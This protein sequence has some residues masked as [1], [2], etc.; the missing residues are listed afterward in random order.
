MT[1]RQLSL[2]ALTVM[3]L[4]PDRM[5]TCAAEAGYDC[6]GL[7]LLPAT[8]TEPTWPCIGDTSLVREIERR[9]ADTG[10]RMLDIEIFRLLP[11]TD[12]HTFRPAL[13]T[14]ARLGATQVLVGAYDR[15]PQRLSDRFGALCDLGAPLGLSM[16]IEPMP[17]TE[18]KSIAQGLLVL[19]SA[20]RHNAG[21]LVDPIHFDRAGEVPAN[22]AA[23]PRARL[24]YM[25]ICD[26]PA[27]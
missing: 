19:E 25:Q 9:L 24:R 16:N 14:G 6:V 27:E 2:G 8:T 15:D 22:I 26:A 7:R 17:W 12:V 4:A 5:V 1:K 3:E 20:G 11:E 10:V 13:E 21:L 23:I 18:V